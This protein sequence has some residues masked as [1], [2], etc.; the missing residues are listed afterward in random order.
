MINL[1]AGMLYEKRTI[2]FGL[3]NKCILTFTAGIKQIN[4][5]T[6]DNKDFFLKKDV[7]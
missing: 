3:S 2:F 1:A 5:F 4:I 7:F 6:E